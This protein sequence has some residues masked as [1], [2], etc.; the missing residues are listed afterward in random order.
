MVVSR[1]NEPLDDALDEL[2]AVD[3]S[4]FVSVRKSLAARLRDAGDRDAAKEVQS[5]RRPTKAAWVLNQLAR[6]QPDV[7]GTLLDRGR[8]LRAAQQRAITGRPEEL[9]AATSAQRDALAAARDAAARI[10]GAGATEAVRTQ[11]GD[12]LVAAS[13]DNDIGEL[14]RRG[15]LVHESSGAT[16][17]PD[18]GGLRLVPSPAAPSKAAATRTSPIRSGR[19]VAQAKDDERA[20]AAERKEAE[21][22]RAAELVS[23]RA[24]QRDARDDVAA[25]DEALRRA[26]ARV[27]RLREELDTARDD[28]RRA[29]RVVTDAQRRQRE[30]D[31]AVTRFPAGRRNPK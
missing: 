28:A 22:A 17:F 18:S 25:A 19:D 20:R 30:I 11:V 4:D 5:A 3:P 8:E 13:A 2:Y 26:E 23:L 1:G 16:G 12:T 10:A 29:R 6:Q 31:Q 15:R 27:D 21:R 14:L 9:R 7:V 24:A